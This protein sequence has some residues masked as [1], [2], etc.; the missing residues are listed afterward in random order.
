MILNHLPPLVVENLS[1]FGLI[2]VGYLVE[3]QF[4][5]RPAIFANAIA[6]NVHVN[7]MKL[8]PDWLVWYA[9]VAV[10]AGAIAICC[11]AAEK[12]LPSEFYDVAKYT[13]A[14]V[15]VAGVIVYTSL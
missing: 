7:E 14:S 4:V 5:S 12:S 10:I 11:Y 8:P 6:I 3:K 9:N 15:P 13:Y 2:V 1:V